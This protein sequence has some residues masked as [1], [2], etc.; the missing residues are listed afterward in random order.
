MAFRVLR[1][2]CAS[3][4]LDFQ[5]LESRG[6]AQEG[7]LSCW[8]DVGHW[9]RATRGSSR[10]PPCCAHLL[11]WS[12]VTGDLQRRWS[13]LEELSFLGGFLLPSP[14]KLR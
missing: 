9:L 8:G 1:R 4:Y 14:A 2:V 12:C 7:D 3:A 6:L 10:P 13:F 11:R 5:G